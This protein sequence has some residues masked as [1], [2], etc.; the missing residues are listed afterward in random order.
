VTTRDLAGADAQAARDLA[1]ADAKAVRDEAE[2]AAR[3]IRDRADQHS[4]SV[5]R[6]AEGSVFFYVTPAEVRAA[7]V[8]FAGQHLVEF[9]DQPEALEWRASRADESAA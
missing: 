8:E 7:L 6:S 5:R 4:V 9:T 2:A 3:V 1:D